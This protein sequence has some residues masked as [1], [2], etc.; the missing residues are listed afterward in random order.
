MDLYAYHLIFPTFPTY[1]V[2]GDPDTALP[3]LRT[4]TGQV[5]CVHGHGKGV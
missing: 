5:W 1:I 2:R 3:S 4:G